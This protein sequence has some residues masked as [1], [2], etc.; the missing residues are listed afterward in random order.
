MK[1]AVMHPLTVLT[2]KEALTS[3]GLIPAE[4]GQYADSFVRIATA[5]ARF[6]NP[7]FIP[8]STE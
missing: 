5:R 7:R 1:R 2:D 4:A 3:L 8:E 6:A